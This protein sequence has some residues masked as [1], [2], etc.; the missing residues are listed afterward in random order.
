MR[1]LLNKS[2]EDLTKIYS[3]VGLL[4]TTKKTSQ[5]LV[6]G[7]PLLFYGNRKVL[8]NQSDYRVSCT[9]VV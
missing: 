8:V 4:M 1:G 9:D 5:S 3:G 2:N 7:D 6:I